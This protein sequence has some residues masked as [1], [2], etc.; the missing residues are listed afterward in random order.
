MYIENIK[1]NFSKTLS[2]F[3]TNFILS[4][5]LILFLIYLPYSTTLSWGGYAGY[6]LQSKVA[7]SKEFYNF[8]EIQSLLYSYTEF[9]RDPI[10]TPIGLPILM[11][12]TS[13]FH[14]WNLLFMKLLIPISLYLLLLTI[15]KNESVG[16][17]RLILFIPFVNPAIIDEFRDIQS[18]I[19]GL[20]FLFLGIYIK[21]SS[22]KPIFFIISILFRPTFVPL[23]LLFFLFQET[24]LK[25]KFIDSGLFISLFTSFTLF[26]YFRFNILISGDQSNTKSGKSGL[27][28]MVDF[29]LN[30]DY[31]RFNF[32]FSEL[33]RLL[34]GFTNNFNFFVGI[35]IFLSSLYFRNYFGYASFLFVLIHFG[36]EAPYFVRYFLPVLFFYF[37][38]LFRYIENFK[39]PNFKIFYIFI[40]IFLSSY[41]LQIAYQIDRL[42]NQRGPYQAESAE[43]FAEVEKYS[44]S[45]LFSFHSPRVFRL[46]TNKDAYRLDTFL[47]PGT[48]YICEYVNEICKIPKNYELV[49]SN[50]SYKM[51]NYSSNE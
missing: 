42:P 47:V 32:I 45:E 3:K 14:S 18:E 22:I 11:N 33:G 49:F 21:K 31:E 12:L 48:I 24:S 38:G 40:F 19:P 27:L 30:I 4:S 17:F 44:D 13:I 34:I 51:Y 39:K 36:W 41:F 29:F 37:I 20:L 16:K 15:F 35:F 9:Q 28:Q 46:F 25:K 26:L 1:S 50:N 2:F 8:I 7:L 10:Y 6:V 23:V 5:F 43:L